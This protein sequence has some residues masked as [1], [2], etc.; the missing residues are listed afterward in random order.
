MSRRDTKSLM[1]DYGPDR[2]ND[3]DLDDLLGF[4]ATLRATSF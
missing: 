4:L 2:V 3:A 1:P